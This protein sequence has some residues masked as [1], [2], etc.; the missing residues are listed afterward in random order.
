MPGTTT[1]FLLLLAGLAA[2]GLLACSGAGGPVREEQISLRRADPLQTTD[3]APTLYSQADPGGN[4]RLARGFFGAPPEIPH[5]IKGMTLD[6]GSNDCLDCHEAPDAKTPG[7]PPSHHVKAEYRIVPRD[8]AVHGATSVFTGF[9]KA[10]TISGNRYNCLLCHVPQAQNAAPLVQNT[11]L[12]VQP[13][14]TAQD[15]LDKL[16]SEGKF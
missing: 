13:K 5:G 10:E 7:L 16:N 1:R 4:A 9:D 3:P 6:A 8:R 12:P 2:A 14:D 15:V 11:F